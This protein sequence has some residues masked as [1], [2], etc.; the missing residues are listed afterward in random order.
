M[1]N[2]SGSGKKPD[3]QKLEQKRPQSLCQI[4][5]QQSN[6]DDTKGSF[7]QVRHDAIE[8]IAA[9]ANSKFALDNVSVTNI[10]ILLFLC[11]LCPFRVLCR[12]SQGW[13]RQLDALRLAP[14]NGLP[15]PVDFINENPLWIAA[16]FLTVVLYGT[17]KIGCFVVGIKR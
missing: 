2:G 12:S 13:P 16:M 10:L 7:R 5:A 4:H 8:P 11:L 14:G 3:S 9:L 17:E 6:A 1:R 15:V